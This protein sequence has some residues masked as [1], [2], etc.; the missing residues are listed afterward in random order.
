MTPPVQVTS[1]K[2]REDTE[3]DGY[4][5]PKGWTLLYAPA[6]RHSKAEDCKSFLIQRHLRDGK[7]IDSTFDPTYFASFGGGN[8]MCIGLLDWIRTKLTV[9]WNWVARSELAASL[10]Y[11]WAG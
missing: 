2:L 11:K 1:R 7:F 9:C 10:Y 5:V 4:V 8:R 3:V 6:G